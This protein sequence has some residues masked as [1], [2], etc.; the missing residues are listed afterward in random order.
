MSPWAS[1]HTSTPP[2]SWSGDLKRQISF[3]ALESALK[4]PDFCASYGCSNERNKKTKQ[5]GITFHRFPRDKQRRQSWAIALRREGFEPKDR[6]VL[7]SCH[8]RPEDFDKSGQ[9]VRLRQGAIPS[10]FKFPD[11]LSK[12]PSSSRL[13]RTSNKAT[14]SPQPWSNTPVRGFVGPDLIHQLISV[15]EVIYPHWMLGGLRNIFQDHQYALDPV[16]AKEKLIVYQENVEKLRRDLRNA[17][18]RERRQK[19]TVSSLLED[20]KKN[21]MLTEELEQKLDFYSSWLTLSLHVACIIL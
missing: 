16:K 6:T 12:Q 14:E 11:H 17:K 8:F 18:D 2:P 7:C 9:T 19:K 21:K 1:K 10:I 4:M 20:L 5:Q 3:P 13:T 15:S